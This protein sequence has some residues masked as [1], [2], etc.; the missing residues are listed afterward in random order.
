MMVRNAMAMRVDALIV[1]E[2]SCSPY[3]RRAVRNSMGAILHLPTVES[4]NLVE[5]LEDLGRRGIRRFAAHPRPGS[6]RISEADFRSDCCVVVGNEGSGISDAV[7]ALCDESVEIPMFHQVD[8]LN[9]S[10]AA[11]IFFYE[12]LRQRGRA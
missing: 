4:T 3:L 5:T 9:V 6:K 10:N 12:V 11:A 7:V 8:S 2:K 1:G